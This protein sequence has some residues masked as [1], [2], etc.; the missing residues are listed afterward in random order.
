MLIRS[1]HRLKKAKHKYRLGDVLEFKFFDGGQ[2]V[3]KVTKLSYG[4]NAQRI[5]DWSTPT[6]TITVENNNPKISAKQYHYPCIPHERIFCKL[7]K[8]HEHRDF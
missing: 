4:Q 6:Y 7:D 8:N 1:F 5:T 3:G 2:K